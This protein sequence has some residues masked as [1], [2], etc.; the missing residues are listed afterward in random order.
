MRQA[1]ALFALALLSLP[2]ACGEPSYAFDSLD[3]AAD[4]DAA[5]A[6]HDAGATAD[7]RLD[8]HAE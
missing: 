1:R 3:A 7:A 5:R 6:P 2:F 8:A 4:G